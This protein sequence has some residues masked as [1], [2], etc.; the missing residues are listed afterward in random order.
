MALSGAKLSRLSL[1]LHWLAT[2]RRESSEL[3]LQQDAAFFGRGFRLPS[4]RRD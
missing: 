3:V 2:K 4:G 1:P